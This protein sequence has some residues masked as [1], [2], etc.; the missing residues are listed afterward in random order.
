MTKQKADLRHANSK[1]RGKTARG[2]A[3]AKPGAKQRVQTAIQR[4]LSLP[5]RIESLLLSG[6]LTNLT[7]TE[8]LIYYKSLCKSLGLNPMT[9]PFE[10]I[11]FKD[12]DEDDGATRTG[13]MTLYA[14]ADCTAQLRRIHRIGFDPHPKKLR[15]GEFYHVEVAAYIKRENREDFGTGI[16]WLK[17]RKKSGSEWKIYDLQGKEL[18]NA[19]MRAETKAKRRATLS[20]CGLHMLDQSEIEDMDTGYYDVTPAGRVV[21]ITDGSQAALP[22]AGQTYELAVMMAQL[23]GK[24]GAKESFAELVK[25]NQEDLK[26]KTPAQIE[27]MHKQFSQ[28]DKKAPPADPPNPT[29]AELV[30][31]PTQPDNFPGFTCKKLANECYEISGFASLMHEHRE[32]LKPFYKHAAK[33]VVATPQE[34]GR[35]CRRF[36]E[37]GA[38]FRIK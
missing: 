32:M 3:Q 8:R 31:E 36:E 29:D 12:T 37:A 24:R 28:W 19:M 30:N 38:K 16:V 27:H 17:K 4:P 18:A 22:E 15:E 33:A 23:A 34:F 20:I 5:E 7:P 13:K 11:V 6:D 25:K 14:R 2:A 1:R 21:E 26:T 10:Y 35:L 9:R